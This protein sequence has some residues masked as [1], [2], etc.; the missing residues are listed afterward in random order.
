MAAKLITFTLILLGIQTM[1]A[2]AGYLPEQTLL[3]KTFDII[4]HPENVTFTGFFDSISNILLA[5]GVGTLVVGFIVTRD[6]ESTV[7][8]GIALFFAAFIA[9]FASLIK[10]VVGKDSTGVFA[11]LI[12]LTYGVLMVVYLI[13]IIDWWRGND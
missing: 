4:N 11:G 1:L 10:Y 9:D 2:M 7:L 13:V 5:F 12:I 6:T 8:A 3:L